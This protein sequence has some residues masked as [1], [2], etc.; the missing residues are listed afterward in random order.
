METSKWNKVKGA[1]GHPADAEAHCQGLPADLCP[2]LPWGSLSQSFKMSTA[3]LQ[4]LNCQVKN[5]HRDTG[6]P[7][8]QYKCPLPVW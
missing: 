1:T 4:F 6:F 7:K 5:L 3:S 8:K 2:M